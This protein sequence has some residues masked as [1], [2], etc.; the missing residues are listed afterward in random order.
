[1]G[2]VTADTLKQLFDSSLA[3][4]DEKRVIKA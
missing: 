2:V 3:G 1:V 4:T